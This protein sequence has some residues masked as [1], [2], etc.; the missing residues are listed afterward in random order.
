MIL[1]FDR[2]GC[3]QFLRLKPVWFGFKASVMAQSSGYCLAADFYQGN[4]PY[5]MRPGD[6]GLGESVVITLYDSLITSFPGIQFSFYFDKFF[7]NTKLICSLYENGMKETGTVKTN[8]MGKCPIAD[9]KYIL[10]KIR[11]FQ[12]W[13]GGTT[14]W[15]T[16]SNEHGVQPVQY[17]NLYRSKEN[18]SLQVTELNV[19][20]KYN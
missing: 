15:C 14:M 4:N 17:A 8:R 11:G 7:T 18:K 16:L 10:R 2:S 1:Y 6:M 3:E 13:H 19:I 20:R 9:K 12:L 5:G